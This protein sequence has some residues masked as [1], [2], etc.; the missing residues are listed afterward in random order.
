MKNYLLRLIVFSVFLGVIAMQPTT[1]ILAQP[2][3]ALN[4]VKKVETIFDFRDGGPE[5]ALSHLTLVHETYKDQAVRDVAAKPRF[6][7]IFMDK[8]VMLV[9]SD[10]KGFTAEQQKALKELDKVVSALVKDGVKLEVCQVAAQYYN[11]DLQTIS[12]EI[13]RVPNGWISSLGWQSKGY[14]LIPAY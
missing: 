7:V 4:G 8:S 6:V 5:S 14:A 11:I 10:R 1:A 12:N 2:Y 9:S 13:K 3:E